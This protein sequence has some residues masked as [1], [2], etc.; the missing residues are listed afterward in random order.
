ME[1][2]VS[3]GRKDTGECKKDVPDATPD[4]RH[5]QSGCLHFGRPVRQMHRTHGIQDLI[6]ADWNNRYAQDLERYDQTESIQTLMEVDGERSNDNGLTESSKKIEELN[7][8]GEELIRTIPSSLKDRNKAEEMIRL[9][10]EEVRDLKNKF[11]KKIE[12]GNEMKGLGSS[13]DED[14][15][16]GGIIVVGE[17]LKKTKKKKNKRKW[18]SKT[19]RSEEK[20]IEDERVEGE[21]MEGVRREWTVREWRSYG[22]SMESDVEVVA[23]YGPWT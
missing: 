10:E 3:G 20:E 18:K 5:I 6:F 7:R 17:S 2:P 14:R 23:D 9:F 12:E 21:D 11:S 8:G 16:I 19:T 22:D 13:G 4:R 15:M 1:R